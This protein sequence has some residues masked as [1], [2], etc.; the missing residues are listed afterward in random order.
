MT[1]VVSFVVPCYKLGHLLAECIQS[2][3]G[4]S[5]RDLEVLIMDDCSP[6]NTAEVGQLFKDE[7]VRYIRNEVNLGHLPNYNKGISMARGK[8]I[9]LISA[10]DCLR[11]PYAVER[12]VQMFEAHPNVG[13]VFCPGVDLCN[14]Q[15]DGILGYSVLAGKDTVFEGRRFLTKL[16][17]ENRIVA[18]AGMVRRECYEKAGM[19]PLDMP[20]GGDWYLWCLFAYH[21]DVAY[22]AEP[23]V[24]YR[25]HTSS[26]THI[27][28]ENDMGACYSDDIRIPWNIKALADKDGCREVSRECLRSIAAEYARRMVG[29]HYKAAESY[30]VM[31]NEQFEESLARNTAKP[32]E[33]EWV[34]ALVYARMAD[35]YY[36]RGQF[37]LARRF[38]YKS[39]RRDP[40]ASKIWAKGLLVSCGKLGVEFRRKLPGLRR[41]LNKRGRTNMNALSTSQ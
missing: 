22:L 4:Q 13:Y 27:L 3:L 40:W 1:P 9:W 38:Y 7:R 25:R 30:S 23:L 2:I 15:E 33:R 11:R 17:H 5:F 28:M 19:F 26:M 24:C 41:A 34:R 6:D 21:F 10:D 16:I 32:S 29:K 14:G 8:Y 36:E 12:Y 31:T 35:Q 20:W 37:A 18:A 39:L